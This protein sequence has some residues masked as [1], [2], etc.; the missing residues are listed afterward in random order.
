MCAAVQVMVLAE[1][2]GALSIGPNNAGCDN[3]SDN[4]GSVGKA[5]VASSVTAI[6]T[7]PESG[8]GGRV[9]LRPQ[10]P[11]QPPIADEMHQDRK[12]RP[13][14]VRLP[15]TALEGRH[16]VHIEHLYTGADDPCAGTDPPPRR[17]R[18]HRPERPHVHT[19]EMHPQ[20]MLRRRH[21]EGRSDRLSSQP[22][23][24]I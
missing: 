23:I 4:A 5:S 2:I 17:F 6:Q 3:G 16:L 7:L 8:P 22:S 19:L 14:N 21:R 11:H 13:G 18:Q 9:L 20:R 12:H 24:V 10:V 1:L 15:H